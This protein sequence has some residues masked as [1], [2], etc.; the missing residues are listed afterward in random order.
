MNVFFMNGT[1][2]CVSL[3]LR[4]VS[5]RLLPFV[6]LFAFISPLQAFGNTHFV[7]IGEDSSNFE[8]GS[9]VN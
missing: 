4:I 6:L 8:A 2:E 7:L 3:G 1:T 5:F 9:L